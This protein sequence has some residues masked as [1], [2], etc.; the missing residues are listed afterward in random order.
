[1]MVQ[2][3]NAPSTTAPRQCLVYLRDRHADR[4]RTK[5]LE[6]LCACPGKA[7]V[8]SVPASSSR[9]QNLLAGRVDV[10]RRCGMENQ[11]VG[12]PVFVLQVLPVK[13]RQRLAGRNPHQPQ[14]NGISKTSVSGN[15]PAV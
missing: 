14:T 10:A 3:S 13:L 4:N 1:M 7:H 15:R 12:V 9:C 11:R 2:G 6:D 8:S 5:G